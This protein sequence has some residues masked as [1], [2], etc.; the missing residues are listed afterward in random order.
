MRSIYRIE[1]EQLKYRNFVK[2][3]SNGVCIAFL[4]CCDSPGDTWLKV[5]DCRLECLGKKYNIQKQNKQSI[6]PN[7]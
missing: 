4:R 6:S 1:F 3:D 5:D 7:F 2:L